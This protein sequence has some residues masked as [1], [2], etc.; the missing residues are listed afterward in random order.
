VNSYITSGIFSIV[1][2]I[3]CSEINRYDRDGRI[4]LKWTKKSYKCVEL[5][6]FKVSADD[7]KECLGC[8]S[9]PPEYL[10]AETK[11]HPTSHNHRGGGWGWG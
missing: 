10:V 6:H 1:Y 4:L 7:V 9:G 11:P 8:T 3:L 5:T 2:D